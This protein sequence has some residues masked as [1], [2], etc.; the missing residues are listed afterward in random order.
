VCGTDL[1]IYHDE[2]PSSPP[3]IMGHEL[4]GIVAQVGEGVTSCLP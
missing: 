3:V 2:Y 4:A 1:H